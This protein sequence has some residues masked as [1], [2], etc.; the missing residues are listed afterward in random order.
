MPP[1]PAYYLQA[2]MNTDAAD[3]PVWHFLATLAL[4]SAMHQ[5]SSLVAEVREKVLENVLGATQGQFGEDIERQAKI[6]NVNLFLNALGL[7]SS[8]IT[9]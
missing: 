1:G 7:D 4:S 3:Q 2:N 6:V 8:Q 9:F 5:Q